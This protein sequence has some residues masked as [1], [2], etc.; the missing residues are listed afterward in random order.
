TVD[1]KNSVIIM[2]SNIGTQWIQEMTAVLEINPAREEE[3]KSRVM[4]ELRLYFRPEFLNRIDEI[5]IFHALGLPQLKEIVEIQVRNLQRRLADRHIYVDLTEAAREVIAREG[6][7]PAYGAR[8]L[9]RAI[10]RLIQDKLATRL[11]EGQFRE[12]DHVLID[13]DSQ[14]Q[15]AFAKMEIAAV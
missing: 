9:K 15:L 2:T 3:V 4:E 11:L 6:Y 1:F 7:D 14:G 10:Q 5:I 13:A 12:G 8:P